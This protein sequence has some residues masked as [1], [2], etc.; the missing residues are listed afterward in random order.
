MPSLSSLRS[1]LFR[2]RPL[3]HLGR[4][5]VLFERATT[6]LVISSVTA[7]EFEI[8]G[9]GWRRP[10]RAG[11]GV[12]QA[13]VREDQYD[14]QGVQVGM[15]VRSPSLVLLLAGS[16]LTASA[17]TGKI[18]A[19]FSS[20]S[21][22]TSDYTAVLDTLTPETYILVLAKGEIRASTSP[23]SLPC[24]TNP[25]RTN[26]GRGHRT[27]YP[28]RAASFREA[29]GDRDGQGL[30][31]RRGESSRVESWRGGPGGELRGAFLF[32]L[33][34]QGISRVLLGISLSTS[35]LFFL[36]GATKDSGRGPRR[37]R[38]PLRISP[39][40]RPRL[41]SA[42]SGFGFRLFQDPHI[43]EPRKEVVHFPSC[44]RFRANEGRM[45]RGSGLIFERDEWLAGGAHHERGR[46][47]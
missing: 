3:R 26:R 11:Q 16:G 6:F 31:S 23:V 40:L 24:F 38:P 13:A 43:Q 8:D 12:G 1:H 15:L 34:W 25:R 29:R 45:R 33:R 30:A 47:A 44:S 36:C 14:G 18:R 39:S 9:R 46:E 35:L 28:T 22:A 37:S 19:P 5:S 20:L 7:P 17:T 42:L 4:R 10:R 21:L 32:S 41:P 27:Q 2:Y